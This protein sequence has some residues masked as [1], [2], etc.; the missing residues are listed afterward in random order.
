MGVLDKFLDIMK[1]TMITK[2]MIS[3]MMIMTMTTKTRNRR[4]V[5]SAV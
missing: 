1:L 2:M 3:S 5:S 4:K